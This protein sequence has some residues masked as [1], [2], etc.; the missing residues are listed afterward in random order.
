MFVETSL[1]GEPPWGGMRN[2]GLPGS[3][4]EMYA[5]YLPSGDQRGAVSVPGPLTRTTASPPATG[6]TMTSTLPARVRPYA[7]NSDSGDQLMSIS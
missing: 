5:R 3:E 6:W 4:L 7:M 1:L 2:T